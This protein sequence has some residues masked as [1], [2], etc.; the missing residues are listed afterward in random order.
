MSTPHRTGF[1]LIELLV[2]VVIVGILAAVALPNLWSTKQRGIR[3]A[4]ISDLR[5]VALQQERFFGDSARYAGLADTALL[6]LRFSP[7]SSALGIVLAGAPAGSTG[8]S[9][10]ISIAGGEMCA[11]AVGAAPLPMGMPAGTLPG[12]PVC[13]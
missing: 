9:A 10:S 7:T 5:N 12:T 6:T 3:A 11:I 8:F 2:V 4:G 1:T 13:W